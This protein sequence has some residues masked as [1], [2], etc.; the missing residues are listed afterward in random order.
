MGTGRDVR[1]LPKA[2]LHVHLPAAMRP[3]TLAEL[4]AESGLTAPD[5]RGFTSF[6]EFQQ[7]F[8]ACFAVTQTR[9]DNLRR[10][11]REMVADAADD[12]V[13]W[14]QPHID[15]RVYA[16]FGPPE[17]VLELLLDTGRDAGR[18]HGVGFGLTFGASR[19][20]DPADVAE[21]ARLAARYAGHGVHALGLTGDERVGPVDP[22]ADAFAIARD[23]GLTVAPHAGELCGAAGVRAA[24]ETLGATRIAHGVRAVEDPAVVDL[25]VDRGVSL[26]VCPTS[27]RILG[28]VPDL[29][30][31]PLPR[32]LA[33]GVR[34]SLGADDPLM[35]GVG[36]ADEYRTARDRL[37]LTDRQL[38]DI[39]RTSVETADAP[40]DL[41]AAA[42]TGIDA[43]LAGPA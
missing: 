41:V 8:A 38:A 42:R 2:E 40:A 13:V 19:H 21:L 20:A 34:C 22:Y 32:L 28:V 23:A 4:A 31:H 14:L 5:P 35:F 7:V 3:D 12:G 29:A 24:V 10:L 15:P 26:D 6:V 33:A 1:A 27:N 39:A 18:R 30:R 16:A 9:P 43:W 17:Q 25:L 36:V 11:V 37:G